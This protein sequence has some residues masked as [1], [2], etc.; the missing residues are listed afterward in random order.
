MEKVYL[1]WHDVEELISKLIM[2]LDTPYDALLLITRG[3]II[4]G[5]MIAEALR[6]KDIL[7]ASVFFPQ[8]A[9]V[10]ADMSWP[11]FCSSPPTQS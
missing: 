8:D 9:G 3:G 1:S 5:G 7:T 10:R 2:Q 6:M 11:R 4:P